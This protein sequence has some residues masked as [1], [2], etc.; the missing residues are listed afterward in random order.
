MRLLHL[1]SPRALKVLLASLLFGCVATAQPAPAPTPEQ[2]AQR[3]ARPMLADNLTRPLRYS[4]DKGDFVIVNGDEFFNR[5]L[6]GGPSPFRVDA[7]DRPELSLFL[8]GRGGNLR[9]GLHTSGQPRWLHQADKIVARYRPGSMIY[10]ISDATFGD[11]IILI[12]LLAPRSAEGAV[13]RVEISGFTQP[14]ELFT[15]FGGI[16]GGR[17]GRDGDVGTEREPV[18]NFFRLQ[19]EF[20][21][22]NT[23]SLAADTFT[24]TAKAGTVGGILPAGAKLHQAPA[25][26]WDDPAALLQPSLSPPA[27]PVV[28]GRVSIANASPVF[29]S[30]QNLSKA[31]TSAEVLDIYQK[32]A[33]AEAPGAV[34]GSIAP[35]GRH[36]LPTLFKSEEQERQAIARRVVVTTPD[37]YVDAAVG[38][39]NIAADAMWDP[40]QSGFVHGGVAWRVRLLGW[41]VA[42]LG[43]SL[44]WPERTRTHFDAYAARQNTSPIPSSLPPVNSADNLARHEDALHSNGD[45]TRSHYDMNMVGVDTFLRHLLWTGDLDY[46]RSQWPV[47]ERHLA[48][49]RRLFRREFG[50]EKLPLYEAYACIW[51]SDDLAYNGGGVTHSTAY[52]LFHHRMAAR[53]ARLLG[54]DPTVY[55]READLI[56]RGLNHHLW[57]PDLGWFAEWKD[58]LGDQLVH[59]SAAAWSFY[60]T[61]DSGVPAPLQAWQ[62]TR[63]VETELPRFDI[64]GPGVPPGNYTLAT[65]NWMPY[66][67]S[68]NNV[69]FGES[70]HTALGLWQANRPEAAFP[71][72]KG[73]LLDS[74]YLGICPGNVGMC[75][76]FDASRRETNR[77]FSDGVGIFARTLVEGLF[78][79]SPDL[80]DGEITIRPGFP[81]AWNDANIRHPNFEFDFRR[82]HE[83]ERFTFDSHFSRPVKVKLQIIALRDTVA[84]VEINGRPAA[85]RALEDSVGLP[86]IEIL[87]PAADLHDIRITWSGH[88]PAPIPAPAVAQPGATFTRSVG[89]KITHL[90]DQQGAL[91]DAD[92]SGSSVAGIAAGQNG[93]RTLFAQVTQGDL[94]W[95]QPVTLEIQNAETPRKPVFTTDWSQPVDAARFEPVPLADV[96]NDRVS[97]IFRNDYLS[98]RSPYVSLAIPRHGFGSWCKP[99]QQFDVDDTGLRA[100]AAKNGDRVLLPNGAPLATPGDIAAPNVAFVSVWD[101]FPREFTTPLNGKASKLYLLMAGSTM[102]M[103]SRKDNGE[104]VVTYT[105]GTTTRLGL[106]NPTTW[107][108]IDEDYFIDDIAFKR[109]G[110]LPVRIDLKSGLIRVLEENAFKGRGRVVPGGAATVLDLSLDPSKQLKSLTVRAIV[111]EVVIGLLSAT[112]QRP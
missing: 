100:L 62:M 72:F 101:R 3:G 16:E 112:L 47:I 10:E 96:F 6:Y 30:L 54:Y 26:S 94:R 33:E 67:W 78:G 11:G 39:L 99:M 91:Q 21:A 60:H 34:A 71:L 92:F 89:A 76:W 77:D 50:P 88:G 90:Q 70:V 42:Y 41:R 84:R 64:T 104:V 95:W 4:P 59:P 66:T 12:T 22:E 20:C 63:Q 37:P 82:E 17:G 68:L 38:A 25:E 43:D 13:L 86:R 8:P 1:P 93:H 15:A 53:L 27:R 48:W 23:F 57:L 61:I 58:L 103:Q 28:V 74:M 36:D 44:G 97:Q 85:W 107:W 51:A 79:I 40:R 5:P 49:Q 56:E 75:T 80:L 45:M 81:A 9:L 18:R 87:A 102:A 7:G 31:K 105:D 73:A 14:V 52:N 35:W 29:I 69:V 65:T 109:P 108:P 2:R 19:P 24:A 111:N 83:V 55:E 32:V 106:E 46:A 98:P 110:P